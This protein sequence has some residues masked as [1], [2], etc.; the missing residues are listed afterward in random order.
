MVHRVCRVWRNCR[1]SSTLSDTY[2]YAS[3]AIYMDVFPASPR[4]IARLIT[5]RTKRA[6][7]P[8]G[9]VGPAPGEPLDGNLPSPLDHRVGPQFI[10]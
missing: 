9:M 6:R 7:G 8:Q 4:V 2:V 5:L 10:D 1:G 3:G